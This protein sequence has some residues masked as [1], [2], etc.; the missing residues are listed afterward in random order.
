MLKWAPASLPPSLERRKEASS[1]SPP[2]RRSFPHLLK[3]LSPYNNVQ[4][5][6]GCVEGTQFNEMVLCQTCDHLAFGRSSQC[7]LTR[8]VTKH[9]VTKWLNGGPA[10][11]RPA[12]AS[13]FTST[14]TNQREGGSEG[15]VGWGMKR[16]MCAERPEF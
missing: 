5:L 6:L 9:N 12:V 10:R 2:L 1:D 7:L 14:R 3:D 11:A 4:P 15:S 8:D 16:G 13:P